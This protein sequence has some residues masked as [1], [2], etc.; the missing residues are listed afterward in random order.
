MSCRTACCKTILFLC[1]LVAI[2]T[3]AT[4]AFAAET[5]NCI[6]NEFNIQ[7]GVSPTSTAASNRLNCTANDVRI[8]KVTNVRDIN[9][10]VLGTGVCDTSKGPCCI[11]GSQF[12]FIAD[13]EVVTSSQSSRSNIGMYI[14]TDGTTLADALSVNKSCADNI[15]PPPTDFASKTRPFTGDS[16]GITCAGSTVKC[17]SNYFDELDPSPDTCGDSSSSDAGANVDNLNGAQTVT[18]EI[19]K[20]TCTPPAGTNTLVLPNCTSWQVPGKT[21]QCTGT[22]GAQSFPTSGTVN[23]GGQTYQ[24][25]EAVPGDKSKCNCEV[26]SLGVTVQTPV[27]SVAKACSTA[28]S[29]GLNKTC[30]SGTE[31]QDVVTYTVTISNSSNIGTITVNQVCDD[32]YGSVLDSSTGTGGVGTCAAGSLGTVIKSFCSAVTINAGS[33]DSS[34]TFT[35]QTTGDPTAIDPSSKATVTDTVS[36]SGTTQ[37]AGS[38]GPKTSNSVTVTPEEATATANVIKGGLGP[39]AACLTERY[40]VE[41]QN[42]TSTSFDETLTLTG[43]SDDAYSDITAVGGKVLGTNCNQSAG[44]GTLKNVTV[45]GYTGGLFSTIDPGKSYTCAFDA[46]FCGSLDTNSCISQPDTIT[47]TL[48]GDEAGDTAFGQNSNKLTVKACFSSSG[49]TAQ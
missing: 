24:V 4:P 14:V 13:F 40:S 12:D 28:K 30:D 32:Q 3:L 33:S 49:I 5:Q 34:C 18:L 16:T 37:F 22:I 25:P 8:A 15:I 10:N 46:E 6:Q 48:K 1:A 2:A 23:I 38:F 44:I 19:Q 7:Q 26:I 17:G 31:G 42:T 21:L 9:G 35:A 43:L 41:V 36:V 29:S 47:A 45:T 27:I 11:S 20:Y 39:Q